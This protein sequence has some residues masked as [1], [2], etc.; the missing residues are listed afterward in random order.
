MSFAFSLSNLFLSCI[1]HVRTY[2]ISRVESDTYAVQSQDRWAAAKEAGK[3][4]D[5]VAPMELKGRK[6]PVIFDTDEHPR[7]A[8]VEKLGKLP[9]TF[10]K[11]GVVSA[12]FRLWYL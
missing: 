8:S 5:E 10:K 11:D 7:Q 2:D 1:Q 9:T 12:G 4:T 3:F 6:G